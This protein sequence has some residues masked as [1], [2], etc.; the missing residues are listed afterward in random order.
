MTATIAQLEAAFDHEL[1]TDTRAAAET[2]YA[3]AF[4]YR[5]EDVNGERRFD[6]AKRWAMRAI[7]LLDAHPSELLEQVTATRTSVG[8]VPIPE[9]LHTGVVRSRLFDV[10]Q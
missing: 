3:L 4:R 7:D 2:A 8:D 5:N 1:A 10:L 9:I 6:L